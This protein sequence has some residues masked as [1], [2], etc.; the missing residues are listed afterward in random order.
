MLNL[1]ELAFK[2]NTEALVDAAN[3]VAALGKS[4]EGLATTFNK[5]E[6]NSS[7][8][9]KAQAK[10][11]KDLAD[12]ELARAKAAEVTAKTEERKN[13]AV[14]D[15]TKATEEATTAAKAQVSILERQQTILEFQANGY[16]KGQSSILAYA[17]A[18]G[19]AASEIQEIGKVL[20]AQRALMGGDPFD[21]SLG[22]LRTL[23]NEFRTL[24][25]VQRLYTAEIP[26]TR[27]QMEGLALDKLRL[28]EAM[29]TQGKTMS[30]IKA[31]IKD[32]NVEYIATAGNINRV[33]KAEDELD[34]AR[35]DAAG[36][37]AYL[38]KEMQRVNYALQAQNNELNKGTANALN[39]FEQNLKRSGLTLDQQRIK[40][41]EYRKSLLALEKTKGGNTD[42][43]T[44]ALGPQITDIF[45]GLATG[46]AP[47]TVMLQQGGQLRDQ[48]A[49]AGVAAAD[50][51]KTMRTAAKD[52]VVSV[53]AVAKAFG[54]LLLGA[55]IDTGKGIV[56]LIGNMTG[57]N[58]ALEYAR[59]QL[60]LFAMADPTFGGPLLK[61]F[62]ALRVA[63][64][65]FA[66]A[67][68]ATGVGALIA[69][70]VAFKQ[71]VS[72]NNDLARSLAL[73]GGAI[74]LTQSSAI[75]Y[76]KA[77]GEVGVT[78]G[79]ATE[80]ITAMAK[81]GVFAKEDIL[82]VGKAASDM[83]T[84]AGI[85]VED[86]VKAFAKLK[87]KPVEALLDIAK[88]TGMVAPEILK[89]VIELEKSGRSADAAA[90]AMKTY[91][92]V[93]ATQVAQMKENYNGFSL[94]IIELGKGI[95]QFFSDTFKTLFL[96]T[97]PTEQLK[98]NLGE[99]Q[100]RI[101]EVQDNQKTNSF[102]GISA[103]PKLLDNLKEQ[104]RQLLKNL[105]RQVAN[106]QAKEQEATLNATNARILEAKN[107]LFDKT[108]DS[109]DKQMKKTKTLGEWTSLY[110]DK[111]VEKLAKAANVNKEQIKLTDEEIR[112]SKELA[113]IEWD[114]AQK[115][116]KKSPTENYFAALMRE[117][118]N[119][120]IQADAATKDLT[121][122]QIKML[123]VQ[124]DPRFAKL[125]EDQKAR[126]LS[127]Y[128]EAIATEQSIAADELK[129]KLL[130]KAAGLG[131]EY[132]D[133]L[134]KIHNYNKEGVYSD[135]EVIQLT[136]ALYKATPAYRENIKAVEELNTKLAKF[137]EESLA[138]KASLDSENATLDMRLAVLGQT[139][140]QQIAIT[141]EYDRQS[142]LAKVTLDLEKRK[143]EIQKEFQDNPVKRWELEMAA[144]EE[145]AEKRK[146]INR[147]VA[148]AYAEDMQKEF[149]RIKSGI[150]DSIVTALFEGGK[151]GGK[152]LREV[153]VGILRQKVTLVVDAV[154]N[155]IL[156]SVIGSFL[157]G[158]SGGGGG[159][160]IVGSIATSL[161][162][163]AIAGSLGGITTGITAG[164]QGASLAAGLAG[165][166]TAGAT[167]AMGIGNALAAIPGWGIAIAGILALGTMLS[168]PSTP[169]SGAGSFYNAAGGLSSVDLTR[170]NN[171]GFMADYNSET[172]AFTDSIVKT[173]GATLNST[174]QVF[175]REAAYE[176]GA[177]FADDS[178]EDGSWGQFTI[179]NGGQGITNWGLE[180]GAGQWAPREFA[181]GEA[182]RA[183]YMR[184]IAVDARDALKDAIGDVAWATDMLDAL[185]D[186]PTLEQVVGAVQEINQIKIALDG[187]G[188][189]IV[190]FGEMTDAGVSALIKASDGAAAFFANMQ[191]F[192]DNFYTDEEKRAN[193]TRDIQTGLAEVGLT[194]PRTRAE[195]R[196]MV[197]EQ[198]ALGESGAE[199]AAALL[200]YSGAFA[201]I[202]DDESK[203]REEQLA[204]QEELRKAIIEQQKEMLRIQIDAAQKQVDIFQ[205]LFDFLDDQLEKLYGSV[206]STATVQ[207]KEAR[208]VIAQ[209]VAS[210]TLPEQ[211]TLEGAVGT[212][213]GSFNNNRYASK[214]EAEKDKLRFA[215]QLE[216]LKSIAGNSLASAKSTFDLLKLQL[217]TLEDQT[218]IYKQQLEAVNTVDD[219][220]QE[221]VASIKSLTDAVN[222]TP[223]TPETTPTP[224]PTSG[225][226]APPAA[227]VN[228]YQTRVDYSSDEALTSFEKFKAW[229][230]GLRVTADQ[231]MNPDYEVPDWLRIAGFA[232]DNSDKELFGSYLFYKNNPQYAADYENIMTGGVSTHSTTGETIV[233]SDLE[234]MPP[235]IRDYYKQNTDTLLAYEGMGADP[236]LAYHVAKFGAESL[237]IDPK[238]TNVAEYLRTH[239]WTANGVVQSN[240]PATYA[241]QGY[242]GY[243]LARYDNDM[244]V[245]V[246]VDG[247]LYSLDGNPVGK[248]SRQQMIAVYGEDYVN[249]M[250]GDYGNT[251]TSRLYNQ[252]LKDGFTPDQY[253][254]NL[255]KYTDQMITEGWSAQRIADAMK[256]TGASLADMGK[257]Y[258]VS[259]SEIADNLR[260][261]GATSL[262]TFAKGGQY[263]GGLALVGEEG[264]ELINF[265]SGGYVHTAGETSGLLS[266]GEVVECLYALN[267]KIEMVEA[268]VRST[269]VSNNKIA[270]LLDRVTPDGNSLQVKTVAGSVVTT[271]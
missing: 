41:E 198:L 260:A 46:Q 60:T 156:G 205:K 6:K 24:K 68:A 39:R 190:G 86:T 109:L 176:V 71:V 125:T 110:L 105:D 221:V 7:Q 245:I 239:K 96:A 234:A 26:L 1:S 112:Q 42:Y 177:A 172:Q 163:R 91:G 236:V 65:G 204:Q 69:M 92:E 88:T 233:K 82:L 139:E 143:R 83:A 12:A 32:L 53:A 254:Q 47:L 108:E 43:I 89:M 155:T 159:G 169:H 33:T 266:Q 117:A 58:K 29:K 151:A 128:E 250:G 243:N 211:E 160:G 118:T 77:L 78:T 124:S 228:P 23:Q 36:A 122:S 114:R 79:S 115:K 144:E 182:G 18:A 229:Y 244:Q 269:A 170:A 212:I 147:E 230:V 184:A 173:V 101:K 107:K 231:M 52:M 257:A 215:A 28:I 251:T 235:E 214:V 56:N 64:I 183:E 129:N 37:N 98:D 186:S 14:R 123:E 81:A 220:V 130:G 66:A 136:E 21:K 95:K 30:Q 265:N 19:V 248:A 270:R 167:G 31:A 267:A 113:K 271:V 80:S 259:A 154:V 25:E 40:M 76:V 217:A 196:K 57:L 132:Y 34:K 50:M 4:V 121:K 84:Y 103:D 181:D 49:L 120:T 55:F 17:K 175:G 200:K 148:V 152:K 164:Y 133:T 97:D 13:K 185:G 218:V 140:K 216:D 207:L 194:M 237:G 188:Q 261:N 141:R 180:A 258:G 224:T 126:V 201:S 223:E 246:D 174:A 131:K 202:T 73:T 253:Y 94:F 85:G 192:Y 2:V 90:L 150:T 199:A 189:N 255:R 45:V 227:G 222:G 191:S 75:E 22:S 8:A 5:L 256:S 153:L 11:E 193:I 219:S 74:G 158:G 195:Y 240:N 62:A 48:F 238:T 35:K 263:A 111:Q 247:T 138:T 142:K 171:M 242:S 206:T 3:K 213:T 59:Y 162:G 208:A 146:L 87:E 203:A 54:D 268:A 15:T 179:G 135:S 241:N 44:R 264:P 225:G 187:L 20:Q 100:K 102:F 61:M 262:P 70:A 210:R 106:N 149:D 9:S 157:G 16:S 10:A 168:K 93:T 134:E 252:H 51:G 38:E 27:K 127:I 161:G 104:E 116:D 232:A 63:V 137:R 178:S 99:I 197:E 165:P 166:T 119:A 145:A 249:A 209:A 226:G 72:E 67:A